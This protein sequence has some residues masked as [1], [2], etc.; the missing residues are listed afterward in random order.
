MSMSLILVPLD[1]SDCASKLLDEAIRFARAF[2]ARLLLLHASDPPR[3]LPLTAM[4]KPRGAAH[5]M[6]VEALLRADAEAHLAPML[7]LA[8]ER[9]VE[10]ASVV[11]FGRPAE[12]IRAIASREH[13]AMIVMGTHGRSG[14]VRA[15][16]G[17]IAEE[18]LRH[19]D[20]PVV[21]VR[22]RHHAGCEASSCATCSLGQTEVEQL[23][24]AEA[25]G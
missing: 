15:T 25:E 24:H 13:V 18:V 22:T 1:F 7:R 14:L 23:V 10:A 20:V 5:P 16:L 9:G 11:A 21:T 8:R 12:V 17:S 19:A 4:L 6:P 2:Q 3:S